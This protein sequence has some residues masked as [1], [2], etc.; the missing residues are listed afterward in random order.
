M[1]RLKTFNFLYIV[2]LIATLTL[3]AILKISSKPNNGAYD[4]TKKTAVFNGKKYT[5][6]EERTVILSYEDNSANLDTSIES[7]VLGSKS[8]KDKRIEVDLSSQKLFAYEGND[9]K[10]SFDVSTGKWSQ[11]PTGEFKVWSKLKYTLMTG[12]SKD[13]GTYYYLP[14]VPYTM[15][16]YKDYGIHGAYWHDNFGHPM[17]HGCV[18]MRI[19]DAEK[20]F[21]WANPILPQNISS[22]TAT[23]ENPG[24]KVIIYGT[25]P[26]E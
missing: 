9:K 4:D 5:V 7:N 22:I 2:P 16:F 10:M 25:T 21:Y 24:T 15:F 19:E 12:G 1:K 26:R 18:N 20:L 11:T 8:K 3:F 13:L 23:E 14:N 17:S 6:P